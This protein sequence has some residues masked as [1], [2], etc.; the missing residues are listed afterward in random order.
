M[1]LPD[2]LGPISAVNYPGA[3]SKVVFLS[4]G[5]IPKD[6][7][8]DLILII[9]IDVPD[10]LSC[11]FKNQCVPHYLFGEVYQCHRL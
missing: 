9:S 7:E 2:P 3:M 8:T 10:F 4:T 11:L 5:F 1:V 6:L